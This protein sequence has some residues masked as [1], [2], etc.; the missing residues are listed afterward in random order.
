MSEVDPFENEDYNRRWLE[1]TL[2]RV[3]QDENGC[4]I[5]QGPKQRR[6]YGI[7]CHKYFGSHHVHRI[8]YQLAYG[9]QLGRWDYVC[10]ACDVT[11]CVNPAHLWIG[12][13]A[14]NQKDMQAKR[15]GKYQQQ[16]EC[17]HG[18]EY[19]A[20]NTW[21]D[22]RGHRHCRICARVKQRVAAG[23]PEELAKTTP[24]TKLGYRPVG[25]QFSATR[26]RKREPVVRS[27]LTPDEIR[28]LL[29]VAGVSQVKGAKLIG[30]GERS[31]R[32]FVAG[33]IAMPEPAASALKA[34]AS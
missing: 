10:H 14:D 22:K 6:G 8:I 33:E 23:W 34:L 30:V 19:N 1:R 28:E 11:A 7:Y 16:T 12:T 2:A 24:V 27:D 4:W 21:I 17:M 18:H 31:M 32:R 13:P 20:V 3:V 26:A 25:A 15:R 9:Q 29:T 5:W